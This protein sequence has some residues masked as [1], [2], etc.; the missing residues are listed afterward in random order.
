MSSI[1]L[2]NVTKEF[3]A[4]KALDDVT[5]TFEEN[6]IYGLLG[7]NGAGK[8]TL[9]NIIS[10]R[11]FATAGD[12]TVDGVPVQENDAA[13]SKIYCMSDKNLYPDHIKI[14]DVF[15][16][17][18]TYYPDFDFIYAEKLAAKYNLNTGKKIRSLSTGYSSI[19]KI[20]IALA[21]N[22]PIVFFDEPVLGLDAH[23][24]DLF[25]KELIDRYSD[26][27]A[28]YIIS[29]HL[30]EEASD[31]IEKVVILKEGKLILDENTEDVLAKG[32]AVSGST[33]AVDEFCAGK[34]IMGADTLGGLKTA[35][36]LGKCD[37]SQVPSHLEISKLD[38]Q[39]MFIQ[40]TKA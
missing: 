11:L 33:S 14:K 4:V 26:R 39:K 2:K 38:L 15:A 28:T 1:Q 21:S 22:A 6:K 7:R 12:V 23:H 27:P 32:Y 24:R 10:N 20:I 37:K 5:I 18:R 40:L 30:I 29:T 17:T 19:Y 3:G 9:L 36:V 31:L 25:Y 8:S 13:L 16:L 34:E 35:Y